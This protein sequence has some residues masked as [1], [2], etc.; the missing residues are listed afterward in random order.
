L[1]SNE[2]DSIVGPSGSSGTE[3][4]TS[5]SA[6]WSGYVNYSSYQQYNSAAAIYAEPSPSITCSK[7]AEVTWAG[8]GGY[9]SHNLAQDGTAYASAG[10]GNHQAWWE[11]LPASYVGVPGFYA[12]AGQYFEAETYYVDSKKTPILVLQFC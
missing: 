6:N 9:N 8:L 3:A 4:G 11:I 2:E 10:L 7:A 5:S 12:T 1:P